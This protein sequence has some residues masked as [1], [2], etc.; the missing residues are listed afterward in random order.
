MNVVFIWLFIVMVS[1]MNY[2]KSKKKILYWAKQAKACG[3]KLK[4]LRFY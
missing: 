4:G 1:L 3:A 2:T